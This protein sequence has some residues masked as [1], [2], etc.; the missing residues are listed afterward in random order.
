MGSSGLYKFESDGLFRGVKRQRSYMYFDDQDFSHELQQELRIESIFKQQ[1]EVLKFADL[2]FR[3]TNEAIDEEQR[4]F[5]RQ[6]MITAHAQLSSVQAKLPQPH[7]A[8]QNNAEGHD[9][10]AVI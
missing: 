1:A 10:L 3:G 8:H 2:C 6:Q 7:S 5:W 4:A 9:H